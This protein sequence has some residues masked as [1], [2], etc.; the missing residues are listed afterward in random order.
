MSGFEVFKA[1]G[2]PQFMSDRGTLPLYQK[3]TLAVSASGAY[4]SN[5]AYLPY[6]LGPDHAPIMAVAPPAGCPGMTKAHEWLWNDLEASMAGNRGGSMY[7]FIDPASYSGTPY[8]V[9]I[10]SNVRNTRASSS[11]FQSFDETGA[12]MRTA[13]E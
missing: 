13:V 9:F 6:E 5:T 7:A 4:A 11:G 8:D 2:V 10:F 1:N 12:L 3:Q